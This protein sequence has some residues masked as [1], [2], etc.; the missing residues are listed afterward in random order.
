MLKNYRRKKDQPTKAIQFDGSEKSLKT[1]QAVVGERLK[2]DD[3]GK[4]IYFGF[5]VDPGDWFVHDPKVVREGYF[6]V[7]RDEDFKD[8]YEAYDY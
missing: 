7:I 4:P 1:C 6:V 2:L 5:I 3:N 8:R